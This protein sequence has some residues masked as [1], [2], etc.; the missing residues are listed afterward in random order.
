MDKTAIQFIDLLAQRRRIGPRIDRAVARV[1]DH[2]R[3][4]LGPEVDEL[5]ERLQ[6]F[7][8]A[9]YCVTCANGTD[10]LELA[11]SAMNVGRGD[12]V[13]V[14]AF[15]YVAT[16]EA[17]VRVGATPVFADVDGE[18]FNL[19]PESAETAIRVARD[20]G[21]SVRCVMPVDLFGQPADY[22]A[23]HRLA[24]THGLKVL[25]DAAQSFGATWR[26]RRVGSLADVTTTSFYPAKPL[27]CYG[28][29]GAIFTNDATLASLLRSLRCHGQSGPGGAFAHVG[30]NSRLDTIQAAVLIEKLSAFEGEIEA[31]NVAA[32]RY[33]ERLPARVIVPKIA[34][35]SESVWA[36]YTVKVPGGRDDVVA[37][38]RAAGVPIAV[39]YATPLH[40]L[41]PY[42]GF[43]TAAPQ[44]K[45]ADA[46]SRDV[47]SLPMHAD[48]DE[49]TQD[50]VIDAM[51]EAVA[52]HAPK[53]LHA[54]A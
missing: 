41:P 20:L 11:L 45:R 3:F 7:S 32:N 33:A 31:R 50:R 1:L 34:G 43:P 27:G 26:G 24:E 23:I 51:R 14:P 44:L 8:G 25:A 38:C 35:G 6:A 47:L 4:V 13:V 36:Q 30:R 18:T 9:R 48:L 5:E 54:Q 28:D 52:A 42:R 22:S 39:H 40:R 17:V 2:G 53:A 16:A 21:L 49:R 10:A 37:S 46:L 15:S 12:A 19:C 29:G